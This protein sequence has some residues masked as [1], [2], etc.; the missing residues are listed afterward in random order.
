MQLKNKKI[1]YFITTKS[2]FCRN[3]YIGIAEEALKQGAK[4]SII[5]R[6]DNEENIYQKSGFR[7]FSY[8]D[9]SFLSLLKIYKKN[10]PDIVHHVGL[11]AVIYGSIIS[12]FVKP[13]RIFNTFLGRFGIPQTKLLRFFIRPLLKKSNNFV[14]TE[15]EED[16]QDAINKQLVSPDKLFVIPG[17]GCNV[18]SIK[19]QKEP[20]EHFTFTMADIIRK[21]RGVEDFINAVKIVKQEQ[22]INAQFILS[23]FTEAR[24]ASNIS[25]KQ[26]QCWDKENIIK[27]WG[28]SWDNLKIWRYSSIAIFPA[29]ANGLCVAI[30]QAAAAGK[31]LIL[32][33]V[34]GNNIFFKNE[35]NALLIPPKNPKALAETMIRLYND[36][37]LRE[38][39]AQNAR[40]TAEKFFQAE[41]FLDMQI[42]LYK[43]GKI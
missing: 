8:S 36:E 5:C 37:K 33:D 19:V 1:L 39:L 21:D 26:L 6:E 4:I 9:Y 15:N 23:G 25:D 11:H 22:N 35:E 24:K 3:N 7:V 38:K 34:R 13:K 31:A 42:K 32:S 10:K 16:K 43:E 27:W 29:Y 30:A 17:F 41:K 20:I 18:Q 28:Y 14:I 40:N 12:K 2:G